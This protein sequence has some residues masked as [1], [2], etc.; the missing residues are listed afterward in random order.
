MPTNTFAAGWETLTKK[1]A[2]NIARIMRGQEILELH[3]R[4]RFDP[5]GLDKTGRQ[6]L[7]QKA[8]AALEQL[9]RL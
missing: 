1:I 4:H 9:S 7:T 5:R 2:A 8:R 6:S 3:Y